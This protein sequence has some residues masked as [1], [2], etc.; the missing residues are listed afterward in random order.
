MQLKVHLVPP[1][2]GPPSDDTV[3]A[4][5]QAFQEILEEVS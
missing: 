1:L 4:A 3:A 2:K 5:K